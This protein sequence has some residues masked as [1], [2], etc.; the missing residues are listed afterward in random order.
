[1]DTRQMPP[2]L[3]DRHGKYRSLYTAFAIGVAAVAGYVIWSM[4]DAGPNATTTR[5][6]VERSQ[7]QPN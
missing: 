2:T 3:Q 7:I 5:T 1:M 4:A 6:D